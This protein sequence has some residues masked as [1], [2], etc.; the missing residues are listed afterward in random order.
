[1]KKVCVV[2]LLVLSIISLFA[3]IDERKPL[4]D[5]YKDQNLNNF[6]KAVSYYGVKSELS[7]DLADEA[8]LM[9]V[10]YAQLHKSLNKMVENADSLAPGQA[11]QTANIL[12]EMGQ[13]QQAIK[14]YNK[15]N[16]KTPNWSC[17]WRHKGE[18]YLKVQDYINSEKALLKAIE[19]RKEH[20]DAYLM[21]A[22]VYLKQDKFKDAYNT[23]QDAFKYKGKDIEEEEEV[24]SRKDID[25]MYLE[26]LKGAKMKKEATEWEKQIKQKYKM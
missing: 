8:N 3:E 20:Y 16:D 4:M 12:L 17:P 9:S 5:Y 23:M 7:K 26:I 6:L 14:I 24:Y 1:M 21:L 19:T 11:F 13:Y 10:V 15:I 18:A 25:L 2:V 22:E